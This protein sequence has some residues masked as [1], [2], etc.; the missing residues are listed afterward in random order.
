MNGLNDV[1]RGVD[2]IGDAFESGFQEIVEDLPADRPPLVAKLQSP[3]RHAAGGM[4]LPPRRR[5]AGCAPRSGRLPPSENEVG[6]S[7]R[8]A[9]ATRGELDRKAALPED[10]DH[11]MVLGQ[12]L[13][14]NM[15]MP[16]S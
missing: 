14:R 11:P 10:L 15:E 5:R 3:P 1:G 8:I 12:H 7:T 2:R 16:L 9:P 13:G 6:S 4:E